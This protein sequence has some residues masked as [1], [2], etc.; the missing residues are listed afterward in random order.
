MALEQESYSTQ[1]IIEQALDQLLEATE[2]ERDSIFAA[3]NHHYPS[4]TARLRRLLNFA[5]RDDTLSTTLDHAAPD[6]FASLVTM[7]E[8]QRLGEKVGAYRITRLINRGGMGVV[9]EAERADGAFEQK[10]AVKFIPLSATNQR[11][12]DLF[13][14]ERHHLAR[15]EHPNIARII[16]AGIAN[17][18]TP[19]FIM[20]YV[21]G[22]SLDEA[23]KPLG[24]KRRL[25]L[26]AQLCDAIAYCH[27]ALIVHGDIKPANILVQDGRIRLLDFGI[28][29][30][31]EPQYL[32]EKKEHTRAFSQEWAAPE[33]IDGQPPLVQSDIYALGVL[34]EHILTQP[35]SL[36][37]AS[38]IPEDLSAIINKCRQEV[39]AHRYQSVDAL[40]ADM[41]AYRQHYPVKARAAS[42]LYRSRKFLRRNRLLAGSTFMLI[43]GLSIGLFTALWQARIA[44]KQA[45][46]AEQTSTFLKSLFTRSSPYDAGETEVTLLEVM[47]DASRRLQEKLPNDPDLRD[48]LK[49]L[50]AGGYSG[51]G[52]YGKS[53]PM[54]QEILSARRARLTPP[55]MDL[56]RSLEDMG[57]EHT[58]RGNYK[59]G[60]KLLREA[61]QQLD[62]L[63]MDQSAEAAYAWTLLGR[64]LSQ[65]DGA[66]S[67]DAMERAHEI[68]ITIRPDDI[69]V[70][71]RSLANIA[72]GL[73]S[74][75]RDEEALKISEKA[76][77]LLEENGESL[78][79]DV[80]AIRCNLG[81]DYINLGFHEKAR[82][83]LQKCLN[84]SIKRLGP[85]HPNNVAYYNNL[86]SLYT[87]LG[88][89]STAEII[90]KKG[91]RI[92][93]EKLAPS[94]ITRIAAEINYAMIL[95]QSGRTAL[96]EKRVSGLIP[97][98]EESLG[99]S[100][101]A[102][103]R[104]KTILGRILLQ[105]GQLVV[106]GEYL[107]QNL[108][109]LSPR[110][111]ADA[112]LWQAEYLLQKGENEE[113]A[114]RAEESV[115]LRRKIPYY[116]DWQVVEAEY[117]LARA[118]HD[119]EMEQQALAKLQESLPKNHARL[120]T[121]DG[122]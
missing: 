122:R 43:L 58:K 11:Y 119:T 1:Q 36:A 38:P 45:V 5:L 30:L 18:G 48:E 62:D 63:G 82:Q 118:R 67:L 19:Y 87:Q 88:D 25:H 78:N 54:R 72:Y 8:T 70:M 79:P 95:W 81:L 55:H 35:T 101:P 23:V 99:E 74:V 84:L 80:L 66:G 90:A 2:S 53:F 20:E 56:V 103:L 21:E 111:R 50:I 68:N 49:E 16:D 108:G 59:E 12:R 113:A 96:A 92:A 13:E 98:L 73:R 64:A 32:E 93:E 22:V 47:N 34:L 94:E 9:F 117:I 40:Q 61:I 15:L 69:G 83:T 100:H 41:E 121:T 91:V 60:E 109:V 57:F 85:D 105:R 106:A 107:Y 27:R 116:T 4:L 89:L 17:D 31:L 77:T 115:K 26:F 110:W 97:A 6:L 65:T 104:V 75:G 37:K 14:K 24:E 76:L 33:Q 28:G 112:L 46:R 39:I 102:T 114:N 52:E 51:L 29:R 10:V 3:F 42:R 120:I 86:G 44:H 7:D 71:G